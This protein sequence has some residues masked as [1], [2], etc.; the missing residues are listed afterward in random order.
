MLPTLF[1][2]ST[3]AYTAL[4]E[5]ADGTFYKDNLPDEWHT[6]GTCYNLEEECLHGQYHTSGHCYFCYDSCNKGEEYDPEWCGDIDRSDCDRVE[7]NC[8]SMCGAYNV[9]CG[10]DAD[11]RYIEGNK[12]KICY[13]ECPYWK[14]QCELKMNYDLNDGLY[15]YDAKTCIDV[16]TFPEPGAELCCST[17]VHEDAIDECAVQVNEVCSDVCYEMADEG[18][19]DG[20]FECLDKCDC[21]F[22]TDCAD[23]PR[24]CNERETC[25]NLSGQSPSL[26]TVVLTGTATEF[27]GATIAGILLCIAGL[28]CCVL[29]VRSH[30][31]K[32]AV[33]HYGKVEVSDVDTDNEK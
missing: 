1:A 15:S 13:D 25:E 16:D 6:P 17:L 4:S 31:R 20:M 14:A 28:L 22:E 3:I 27:T 2:L 23:F 18:D 32:K 9:Q 11:N 30:G 8:E 19:Y 29:C 10:Y 7:A 21:Y 33:E 5:K 26:F 12:C 24:A